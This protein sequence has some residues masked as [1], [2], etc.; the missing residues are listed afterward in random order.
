VTITS[1]QT[2][3]FT[4]APLLLRRRSRFVQYAGR[5]AAVRPHPLFAPAEF[6]HGA[7][8]DHIGGVSVDYDVELVGDG[9]RRLAS[10][11]SSPPSD[12]G[13]KCQFKIIIGERPIKIERVLCYIFIT[14]LRRS[15]ERRTFLAS[16][17]I[18]ML[19]KYFPQTRNRRMQCNNGTRQRI[20]QNDD[21]LDNCTERMQ[22]D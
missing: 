5:I 12:K 13:I 18:E 6:D 22:D 2:G 11:K 9:A 3:G 20:D 1:S 10:T 15:V 16:E 7:V 21:A 8:V 17:A 19:L 4:S 14:R